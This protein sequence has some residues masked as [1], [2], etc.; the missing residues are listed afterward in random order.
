[1]LA[2][3]WNWRNK[4]KITP[5]EEEHA[6]AFLKENE[7]ELKDLFGK[8][9][10]SIWSAI[11]PDGVDPT[12][13]DIGYIQDKIGKERV[14]QPLYVTQGGWPRKIKTA[15]FHL[16]I[17]APDTDVMFY[18]QKSKRKDAVKSLKKKATILKSNLRLEER[19]G[20]DDQVFELQ[21]KIQDCE[22]LQQ[23]IAIG[24]ND[25]FLV[26][27]VANVYADT[28]DDLEAVTQD[29]ANEMAGDGFNLR[30]TYS[31][32]KMGF[33]SGLPLGRNQIRESWRNL[34]RYAAASIFPFATNELEYTGHH[35]IPLGTNKISEKVVFFDNY[36]RRNTN[37]N[38]GIFG[39]S[40]AGKSFAVKLLAARGLIDD[41]A[42]VFID[43]EK[44]YKDLVLQLGGIYISLVEDVVSDEFQI[45]INPCALWP[46]EIELDGEDDDELSTISP[47]KCEIYKDSEGRTFIR[48]VN[49]QEKM[50]EVIDFFEMI[51][52]S[53]VKAGLNAFERDFLEDA[54]MK[55]FKKRGFT[56]HPDSLFEDG[57]TDG[58]GKIHTGR[59]RKPEI[60]I[61]DIYN[62]LVGDFG[63]RKEAQE[64][65]AAIRPC[66][67]SRQSHDY[68]TNEDFD[69]RGS[70]SMFDG[71][72]YFGEGIATALEDQMLVGFD[73]SSFESNERLSEIAYHV[74]FKWCWEKFIKGNPIRKKRLLC[75]EAW[76]M[77]D[78]EQS[79]NFLEKAARR[80]RKRNCSLT[81]ATQDFQ[82]LANNEKARAVVSNCHTV[83][84][85]KQDDKS[86]DSVAETFKLTEGEISLLSAEIPPGEG[87]LRVGKTSVWMTTVASPEEMPFLESNAAVRQEMR[88]TAS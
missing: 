4:E 32:I 14:F 82:R 12:A 53:K 5:E 51:A 44:E 3:I 24:L 80:A 10:A 64:L 62:Q 81:I 77:V 11:L 31:R 26:A 38:F 66:L 30:T 41:I 40:G 56:Q 85:M 15:A 7:D 35:S 17:N 60:T 27:V 42:T 22:M 36:S 88:R 50:N 76:R 28:E 37:Y 87:I 16:L 46:T 71:Q 69:I 33:T 39:T 61:S 48:F 9:N 74:I 54:I 78:D 23:E 70:M 1:M 34:D 29:L 72:S 55:V 65:I 21:T 68:E 45:T 75:D 43:P 59:V 83:F 25:Q 73:L 84:F 79:V 6:D 86:R 49:I 57:H 63:G 52:K 8:G 2:K 13:R 19:R 18:L 67:R 20:N 58:F 47:E